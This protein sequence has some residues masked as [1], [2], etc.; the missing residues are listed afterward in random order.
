MKVFFIDNFDLFT[1]N[2][3][4]EFE[5]RDCEVIVYRNNVDTKVIDNVIKK[6]KP[7][8]IVVSSGPGNV[9]NSGNSIDVIRNYCDNV[10]IF[11]VGLG[12]ECI[13]EAFGGKVDR[14]PILLHGK[15]SKISHDGKTIF[16][17]IQIPFKAGRFN[18]LAGTDVPYSLEVSARDDNDVVV[19][20]RHKEVFVEGIQ[21]H[22][23]SILT[24]SGN[25]LIENLIREV[26]KK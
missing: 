12:H 25:L 21:F 6:F 23:E 5:K 1:F 11:G 3:V 24:P 4:D 9:M 16:K 13:I 14:S 26:S 22:P 18:S 19:S 15:T 8:L 17:K 10:P 2:L 7:H 20:V